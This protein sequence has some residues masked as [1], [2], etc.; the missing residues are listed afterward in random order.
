MPPDELRRAVSQ[1]VPLIGAHVIA[2]S[3]LKGLSWG[4][5][6]DVVLLSADPAD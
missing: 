6:E 4:L 5:D 1:Y 2:V 3:H